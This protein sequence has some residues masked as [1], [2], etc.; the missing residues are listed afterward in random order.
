MRQELA[1]QA[2]VTCIPF[3]SS[4]C[5]VRFTIDNPEFYRQLFEFGWL[6]LQT[7]P[8]KSLKLYAK[9]C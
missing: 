7:K 6:A 5:C 4:S 1:M 2:T 3:L 8:M 9:T